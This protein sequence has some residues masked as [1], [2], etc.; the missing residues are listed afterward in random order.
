MFLKNRVGQ[1]VRTRKGRALMGLGMALV[2][3]AVTAISASAAGVKIYGVVDDGEGH[4]VAVIEGNQAT[5]QS[6]YGG[7]GHVG[8]LS[9]VDTPPDAGA[10]TV[11]REPQTRFRPIDEDWEGCTG[12]TASMWCDG[13]LLDKSGRIVHFRYA[14]Q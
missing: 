4:F 12:I 11:L 7:N 8:N 10:V 14:G 2:L 5:A 6:I 13:K 1:F 3:L 9:G